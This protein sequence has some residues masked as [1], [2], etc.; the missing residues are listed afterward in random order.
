MYYLLD[1]GA[2]SWVF[3]FIGNHASYRISCCMTG[4]KSICMWTTSCR[5]YATMAT[6]Q[7]IGR[8]VPMK[9]RASEVS[10]CLLQNLGFARLHIWRIP[11]LTPNAMTFLT[12]HLCVA[13]HRFHHL[14]PLMPL[15]AFPSSQRPHCAFLMSQC[16]TGRRVFH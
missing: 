5:I 3:V 8:H 13:S 11:N 2:K 7:S 16:A 4:P 9:F 14:I 10:Y 1:T 12:E 6:S 15:D